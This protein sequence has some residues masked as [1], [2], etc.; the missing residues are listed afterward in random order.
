M[1]S[2]WILGLLQPLELLDQVQLELRAQP[3]TELEGDVLVRIGAAMCA[4]ACVQPD[5]AGGLDPLLYREVKAVATGGVPNSLEFEGIEG[6]VVQLLPHA[7]EEHRVLVA[8]PLLNERAPALEEH[9]HVGERDVVLL[10]PLHH[11]DRDAFDVDCA[12]LHRCCHTELVVF[13]R[14]ERSRRVGVPLGQMRLGSRS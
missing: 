2:V 4:S 1:A 6:G 10:V 11:G 13:A 8:Q 9:D 7:E 12:L 3:R 5:G 14:P